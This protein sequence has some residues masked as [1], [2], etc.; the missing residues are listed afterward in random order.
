M[1]ANVSSGAVPAPTRG[2][3]LRT[4][5]AAD[6]RAAAG[7]TRGSQAARKPPW[8]QAGPGTYLLLLRL[9][10]PTG[11]AVGRLGALTLPAGWYVYVG[12]ALGG[13]G[14][15]LRRHLRVAKSPH[16]HVDSLRAAAELVAVVVRFGP[17]R[18]ECT[19][20]ARVAELPLARLA[21]PRFG[22][23][24]CRCPG[25]LYHFSRRPSL[26]LDRTWRQTTLHR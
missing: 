21:V 7:P 15:R 19:V 22:A 12:S 2:S 25:H 17:E 4:A 5:P 6:L 8:E 9:P 24:D 1:P 26:R 18:L 11:L 14:P 3:P 16:W 13:L 20:A 10:Q 23:S